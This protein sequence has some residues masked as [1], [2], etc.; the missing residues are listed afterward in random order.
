MAW[1]DLADAESTFMAHTADEEAFAI[2][3]DTALDCACLMVNRRL[4]LVFGR[5]TNLSL[6]LSNRTHLLRQLRLRPLT[7]RNRYRSRASGLAPGSHAFRVPRLRTAR[8]KHRAMEPL[9]LE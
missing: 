3:T 7:K 4:S 9:C 8:S 1:V 2:L 5:L 6:P